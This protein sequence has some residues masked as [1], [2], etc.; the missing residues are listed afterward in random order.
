MNYGR[1]LFVT[2]LD[3]TLTCGETL[4]A[5]NE[6]AIKR[7][8][9]KG[10]MFTL[11]TGRTLSYIKEKFKGRL[12][13]NAPV[14]TLN[15][16]IITDCT[17]GSILWKKPLEN[18]KEI[19]SFIKENIKPEKVE[20]CT[21]NKRE[22]AENI[23]IENER[24]YKIVSVCE[25]RCKAQEMMRLMNCRFGENCFTMRSWET[26]VETIHKKAGKGECIRRVKEICGA[27]IC[28]AIGDYENDIDMI[29]R[30][31]IGIAVGNAHDSV[32]AAADIVTADAKDNAVAYV[33][34]NIDKICMKVKA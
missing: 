3:A 32:K 16:T 1:I 25:N 34:E 5:E 20:V 33:L 6:N 27:D 9:E 30:A 8:V 2:D 22:S 13:P 10:G 24:V 31:D 21:L 4:S 17:D 11:A 18:E 19:I 15:G 28:I 14:T 23:S 7:F 29:K 26:G 12:E